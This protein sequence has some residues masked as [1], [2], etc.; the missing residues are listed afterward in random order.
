MNPLLWPEYSVLLGVL[1]CLAAVMALGTKRSAEY[2]V[3]IVALVASAVFTVHGWSGHQSPVAL[4]GQTVIID[5]FSVAVDGLVILAAAASILLGWNERRSGTDFPALVLLAAL[6]MMVLGAANSFLVLFLGIELLSLPLYILA[7]SPGTSASGEAGL[8]YLLLGAFSSGILLFGLALLYGGSGTMIF[9]A[10]G[11]A[12]TIAPLVAAGSAL[13]LVGLI[14]KLGVVPF[15]M[16]VPDVYEGSSMPVAHF[17]AFGTKVGAAAILMRFLF[18]G[19]YLSPGVW[20]PLIGYL[21]VLT[22]IVG[23]LMALP[24]N[25]LKRLL[26][27]S[28]IGNAGYLLIGLASHNV[29]GAEAMLFYLLPYGFAVMGAFAVVTMV[30][31]ER[32]SISVKDLAGLSSRS[33]ALSAFFVVAMLSLAGIPLTGG[34]VGKFYLLQAALFANQPGLAVGL[35][36]ATLVGMGAYLRPLL[37]SFGHPAQSLEPIVWPWGGALVLA[38]ATLGTIGL[39]VYPAPIVQIV[40]HSANFFWLH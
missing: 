25:D 38:V 3:S 10:I 8:K 1:A 19:F 13:T 30:A 35:V 34:F 14:F 11:P 28:G 16:W 4:Y 18:F 37:A 12:H 9:T 17:M 31:G 39:G 33:P 22:M 6:G 21:G 23:N 7:A 2:P 24:Q 36:L 32:S 15:H 40:S 26:A 27:Y 20:G 5:N 29:T